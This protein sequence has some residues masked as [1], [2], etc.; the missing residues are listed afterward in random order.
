M[1]QIRSQQ[2]YGPMS[3]SNFP[4]IQLNHGPHGQVLTRMLKPYPRSA[5]KAQQ[6][7]L[8]KQQGYVPRCLGL[9]SR[10]EKKLVSTQGTDLGE[11]RNK[12]ILKLI[13]AMPAD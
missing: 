7:S 3:S 8:S 6:A 11:R 9:G 5:G 4:D 1:E 10:E 2:C 12:Y 13:V